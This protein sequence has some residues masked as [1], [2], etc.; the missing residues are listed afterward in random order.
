MIDTIRNDDNAR[1]LHI[2]CFNESSP[3]EM[4]VNT[5]F[6]A[7]KTGTLPPNIRFTRDGNAERAFSNEVRKLILDGQHRHFPDS[8]PKLREQCRVDG[9][10]N[11]P[12]YHYQTLRVQKGICPA[13]FY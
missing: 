2:T 1:L 4:V 7:S 11:G 8:Y 12:V 5:D 10:R 13:K 6:F 9:N 3:G